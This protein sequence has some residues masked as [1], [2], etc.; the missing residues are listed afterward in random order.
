MRVGISYW[1][2]MAEL[3]KRLI[4]WCRLREKQNAVMLTGEGYFESRIRRCV[5]NAL[6]AAVGF[7]QQEKKM[8]I[9]KKKFFY[10]GSL[11]QLRKALTRRA[12]AADVT[13]YWH[14]R[15]LVVRL[16]LC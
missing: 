6:H 12:N 3:A 7:Q 10:S 9:V 1:E 2:K 16:K 5:T 14:C 8:A 13:I 15:R 11:Y 4:S